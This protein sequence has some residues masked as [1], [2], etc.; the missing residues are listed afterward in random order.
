M[1]DKDALILDHLMHDCRISTTRLAKLVGVSQPT[2][3]YR[4]DK[5]EKE[6]ID[7]YDM[8][9]NYNKLDLKI[10][11]F[12]ITVPQEECEEF[13][14]FCKHNNKVITMGVAV[15]KRNYYVQA[16]EEFRQELKYYYD[17]YRYKRSEILPFTIS[18]TNIEYKPTKSS[19]VVELDEF[20]K[21]IIKH[22][23]DGGGRDSILKIARVTGLT[24]DLVL[25]RFRKLRNAGYFSLFIAQPKFHI[26]YIVTVF[27][28]DIDPDEVQKKIRKLSKALFF[29]DL[30]GNY[31]ATF[32]I[33]DLEEYHNTL[34]DF[35]KTFGD[36]LIRSETYPIFESLFSNRLEFL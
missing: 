18:D 28:T 8:I 17:Y 33:R 13:E 32:A 30:D 23:S 1:D 10:G 21:I 25:Y 14:R 20:D 27:K 4:I 34:R 3:V 12:L 7:K 31:T 26:N 16:L 11:C 24:P 15:H 36:K 22:L 5:L 19:L 9:V 2:V 6:Y 35:Y 29:A